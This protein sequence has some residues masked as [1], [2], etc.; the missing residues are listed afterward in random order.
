M[1]RFRPGGDDDADEL[2]PEDDFLFEGDGFEDDFDGADDW[3]DDDDEDDEL[4]EDE[5]ED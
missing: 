3:P 1:N 2:E 4:D 5:E